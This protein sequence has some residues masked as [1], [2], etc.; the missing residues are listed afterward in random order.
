[1]TIT[2]LKNRPLAGGERPFNN[3]L[4]ILRDQDYALLQP[5]LQF[6]ELAARELLYSPGDHVGTVYFPCGPSLVS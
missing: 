3:L 5:D 2:V 6:T 4:R 1:V